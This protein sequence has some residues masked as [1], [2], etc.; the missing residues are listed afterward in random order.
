MLVGNVA[1]PRPE[2]ADSDQVV[3][4]THHA[5]RLAVPPF[6][7]TEKLREVRDAVLAF[8]RLRRMRRSTARRDDEIAATLLLVPGEVEV[9]PLDALRRLGQRRLDLRRRMTDHSARVL[10]D[11]RE[12]GTAA[13][14]RE[15][16]RVTSGLI[17]IGRQ[18][19]VH[20]A[21]T[22]F[23]GHHGV[24]GVEDDV[25]I[26]RWVFLQKGK[27]RFPVRLLGVGNDQLDPTAEDESL[28]PNRLHGVERGR[29]RSLVVLD[30]A[31]DETLRLVCRVECEGIRRPLRRIG[32]LDVAVR[33]QT[34]P[35]V[36]VSQRDDDDRA[37][38]VKTQTELGGLVAQVGGHR[39]ELGVV[40]RCRCP[41]SAVRA[42]LALTIIHVSMGPPTI[43]DGR[44]SRV[45]F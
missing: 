38:I 35:L 13:E 19:Q 29:D 3:D 31:P 25:Q 2:I 42:R 32:R 20:R 41:L 24:L 15:P 6:D 21:P 9:D 34:E 33:H 39:L 1:E 14:G 17:R 30:A 43:P 36:A 16:W 12:K 40:R 27:K 10:G 45:R 28:V 11:L 37:V 18:C 8:P 26:R 5:R 23:R 7:G 4:Q 44:I 22:F